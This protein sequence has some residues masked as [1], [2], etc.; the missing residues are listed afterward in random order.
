MT[1]PLFGINLEEQSQR[2]DGK[3]EPKFSKF[4]LLDELVTRIENRASSF[5]FYW[6]R[7]GFSAANRNRFAQTMVTNPNPIV[8]PTRNS[9][10]TS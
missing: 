7:R 8:T 2:F 1:M 6:R 10:E 5:K 4:H 9:D 3:V